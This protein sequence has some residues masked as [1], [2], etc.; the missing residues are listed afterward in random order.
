MLAR[1]LV[2]AVGLVL[3]LVTTPARAVDLQSA[4]TQ[5][6]V[7]DNGGIDAIY[8]LTFAD[9]E[10]RSAI[11][12][13]GQFYE[14]MAFT[15][16]SLKTASGVIAVRMEKLGDGYYRAAFERAQPAGTYQ[17]ELHFRSDYRLAEPT[18]AQGKDV[19]AV[20]FNP[21]RWSMPVQRS[22]V[23]LVL[24]LAL[25]TTLTRPEDITPSMVDSLG[26]LSDPANRSAQD[27][28]ALVYADYHAERRLTVYAER[29]QLP[30]EAV[31]SVRAYV[32]RSALPNLAAATAAHTPNR[33]LQDDA[34]KRGAE[35]TTR[36]VSTLSPARVFA[37]LLGVGLV[38]M[39]V[40]W[41][42]LM[43]ELV[44]FGIPLKIVDRVAK[45]NHFDTV[46]ADHKAPGKRL[47]GRSFVTFPWAVVAAR[48]LWL[49]ASGIAW[50]LVKLLRLHP[51]LDLWRKRTVPEYVAPEITVS[52]FRKPGF[53]PELPSE[54]AALLIG[55]P[56]KAIN[57]L[58]LK[59]Q[60][61]GAVRIVSRNPLQLLVIDANR[62]VSPAE[63]VL[64]S[65][66]T[67]RGTLG[68]DGVDRVLAELAKS[69]Q[70]KVWRADLPA[71]VAGYRQRAEQAWQAVRAA[72]HAH[73]S[74][75]FDSAWEPLYLHDAFFSNVAETVGQVPASAAPESPLQALAGV[76]T[77]PSPLGGLVAIQDMAEGVVGSIERSVA[78]T[79]DQV[80]AWFGFDNGA[81]KVGAA[82]QPTGP[83]EAVGYDACHSACHSACHDACHSA[84]HSACHDACHS[85]CHDACACHSA[86]HDACVSSCAGSF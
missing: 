70:P 61:G 26:F 19:L 47:T 45:T 31:H 69:T 56:I 21:V 36:A 83:A 50:L 9:T 65:A 20:W 30:S 11:N 3:W 35:T 39:L 40:S 84:C 73:R 23:K 53:V 10:G 2:A 18:T 41:P 57:L 67:A 81:S 4:D 32:P 24:P 55:R 79:M 6:F 63:K 15:R 48:A 16:A 38:W 64:L 27:H 82:A 43:L 77:E 8:T 74:R 37:Y 66:L 60:R 46:F 59:L 28:Y 17:L 5:A 13:I 54:E 52:T 58:V 44:L 75:L 33:A 51:M 42:L 14:P 85:A 80:E 25:P 68:R 71:T 49:L 34:T 7:Q 72:P 29:R 22:V 12:K 62:A 76:R 1:I 78:S 86:C